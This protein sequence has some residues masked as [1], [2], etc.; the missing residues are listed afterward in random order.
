ME[1]IKP[2]NQEDKLILEV[3]LTADKQIAYQI[4]GGHVPTLCYVLKLLEIEIDKMI[5]DN[6]LRSLQGKPNGI[7]IPKKHG[8]VDFIR[9][10]NS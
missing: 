4:H 2:E 7:I 5:I 10:K 3:K 9:G 8:I 1:E 6:K